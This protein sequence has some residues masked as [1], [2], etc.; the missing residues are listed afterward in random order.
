MITLPT[1]F[2][3]TSTGAIQEWSI[4][5]E[6]ST[7]TT[8]Y[9]QVGGAMQEASDTLSEGKNLGKANATTAAEQAVKEAEARHLKQKKKGYVLTQEAAAAGEVDQVIEGGFKP[10]LAAVWGDYADTLDF[11]LGLGVQR[12]LNGHRCIAT[13]EGGKVSLWS[14]TRKRITSMPHIAAELEEVYRAL[15]ADN[16]FPDGELYL[17]G[18][19]FEDLTRFIRHEQPQPGHGKIEYHVYDMVSPDGF[20]ARSSQ[21]AGILE[22]TSRVKVVFVPTYFVGDAAEVMALH[23][24]FRGEGYE[25][26]I[27]RQCGTGYEHK[28]TQQLLKL[29]D[30][31]DGEFVAKRVEES[32]GKY[33]G[34]AKR[35]V[36][37]LSDGREFIAS[38]SGSIESLRDLYNNPE[39]ILNRPVHVTYFSLTADGIPLFPVGEY[40]RDPAEVQ[41]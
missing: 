26:T 6:G 27:G 18:M 32:R 38:M 5:V 35:V 34:T 7:I 37:A 25:G 39:K 14:R 40:V 19:T 33:A 30:W 13:A 24:Q 15:G 17:H 1:L 4:R 16:W 8:T 31:M 41:P 20:R 21:L 12:K 3:K 36:C 23:K 9:G 10:M 2:K 22:K 29:K 28:R 11:S